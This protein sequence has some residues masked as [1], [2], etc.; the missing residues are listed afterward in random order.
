MRALVTLTQGYVLELELW[1]DE[2]ART[3]VRI[4]K[5]KTST[6]D[7]GEDVLDNYALAF[8]RDHGDI[9]TVCT[10]CEEEITSFLK[11]GKSQLITSTFDF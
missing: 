11:G 2:Q 5:K 10:L 6:F 9:A 1:L 8:Y 7:S 3:V 4:H